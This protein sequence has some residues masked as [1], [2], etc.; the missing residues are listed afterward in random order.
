MYRLRDRRFDLAG[1][2]RILLSSS[3]LVSVYRSPSSV[4]LLEFYESVLG[5][6][7]SGCMIGGG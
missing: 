3:C 1:V 4:E 5:Y 7:F 6:R 2:V